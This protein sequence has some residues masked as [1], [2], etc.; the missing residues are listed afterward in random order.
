YA[1]F[2]LSYLADRKTAARAL[3]VLQT[4]LDK[5]KDEELRDRARIAV[6][7][8]DPA[9]LKGMDR[10]D[11]G[12][13]GQF[14]KIRVFN[15]KSSQEEFSLNIPLALADLALKSL[16]AEQKRTLQKEG[17]NLD[18]ILNQLIVKGMKIDIKD[19]DNVIK[20]WV[21]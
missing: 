21:E 10:Q 7:R 2:K 4:I 16:G 11:K 18:N 12:L 20:I 14:L 17:Y 3:P 13:A 19:E 6:M 15:K 1:A 5:E 8:I 9:R